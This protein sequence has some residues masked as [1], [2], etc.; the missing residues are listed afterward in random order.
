ME[1]GPRVDPIL[2]EFLQRI[3]GVRPAI[4]RLVLFGSRARGDHRPDSDYDL[5]VVVGRRDPLVIDALYDAVMDILLGHGRL[6]S[7]KILERGELARLQ[8]LGA[9]F[10]ARVAAEGVPVG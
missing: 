7:L 3:A 6:V 4:E 9:P 1:T 2:A 5:L 8:A 10:V